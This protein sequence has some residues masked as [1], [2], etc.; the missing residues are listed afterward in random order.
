MRRLDG[1]TWRRT[2][3]R[4]LPMPGWLGYEGVGSE[5]V[6]SCRVRL[7][8]NLRGRRFPAASTTEESLAVM[9][10]VLAAADGYDVFR[11]LTKAERDHYVGTRLLS[12][13]FPWT[14]PG[15]A[16]LF[17]PERTTAILVN[18]E[19]HLRLQVVTGGATWRTALDMA[20]A[21]LA[22]LASHLAFA[23]EPR[24]GYLAAS[25]YNCGEG[26]RISAMLH[27]AGLGATGRI[28]EVLPALG[29]GRIVFRGFSANRAAPW[30]RSPR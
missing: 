16:A 23:H 2:A 12:P 9:E 8:R 30:A 10:E 28:A 13:D 27:L 7:M 20:E 18:E 3:L 17:D 24:R 26:R 25:V 5:I 15:R 14:K 29:S 22:A 4:A 6:L 21:R 19:D 11:S 1:E